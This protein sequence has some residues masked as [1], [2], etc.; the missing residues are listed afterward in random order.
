MPIRYSVV[1]NTLI[2][3]RKVCRARV[4]TVRMV[5]MEE[6]V[7]LVAA[8]RASVSKSDVLGVV[9]LMGRVVGDLLADGYSVDMPWAAMRPSI[10][11]RFESEEDEFDP[12]RHQIVVSATAGK[13]VRQR[14]RDVRAE[15]VPR[16][17]P[18]P[19]V[20]RCENP[21]TGESDILI[22]GRCGKLY[23][24]RLKF[25]PADPE[26]GVFFVA[27][28]RSET[29]VERVSLNQPSELIFTVPAL[30]PGQYTVFVRARPR[31]CPKRLVGYL[32]E[33]LTVLAGPG[34][35]SK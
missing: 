33:P 29:R 14:M 17:I 8:G 9:E 18:E 27:A 12:N 19:I 34:G 24:H 23:G 6:I 25:D 28:N 5:P 1:K 21:E 7:D 30:D 32:S 20:R 22:S 13:R 2:D 26:Q 10:R 4:H 15:K 31:G 11:G 35:E 16:Q 3:G